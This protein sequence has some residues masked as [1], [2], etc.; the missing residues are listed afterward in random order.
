MP[1]AWKICSSI[2]SISAWIAP[3]VSGV[4]EREHLDLGELVDPV[5]PRLARPAAPASVRKQCDSP[6]YLM[7][8]S[9]LVEQLV[10]V[11]A[12]QGDLGGADQ[13][14]V[15]VLDRVDLGLDPSGRES[16]ALQDLLRA[17][18]GVMMG[19]NPARPAF[20]SRTAGGPGPGARRRS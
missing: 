6:T 13:A 7:G 16:D 9:A 1:S 5:K 15:G 3:E 18:S 10:G 11:H 12:A 4:R 19:V 8:N 2:A 14:E 20:G 17:R